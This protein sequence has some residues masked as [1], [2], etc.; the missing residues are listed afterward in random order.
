MPERE[1]FELYLD[2]MEISKLHQMMEAARIMDAHDE[3]A[4][5]GNQD[6]TSEL[7]K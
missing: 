5:H 4:A 3:E 1:D 2:A 6:P 7:G